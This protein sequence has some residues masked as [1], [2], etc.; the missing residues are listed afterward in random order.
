M[1]Q[2]R[3]KVKT[4]SFFTKT[5][6]VWRRRKRL[7]N[8]KNNAAMRRLTCRVCESKISACSS[9]SIQ[10]CGQIRTDL[11]SC[12]NMDVQVVQSYGWIKPQQFLRS[13]CCFSPSAG[14]KNSFWGVHVSF[15]AFM[16]NWFWRTNFMCICF[17]LLVLEF[18]QLQKLFLLSLYC[19]SYGRWTCCNSS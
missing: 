7:R 6:F 12:T 11:Y 18:V 3:E 14:R 13:I 15:E 10:L 4:H 16:I 5:I 2:S 1:G 8:R 17:P 9:H 19:T